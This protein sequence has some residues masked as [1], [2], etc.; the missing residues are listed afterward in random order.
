M[1]EKGSL[2]KLVDMEYVWLG[3]HNKRWMN[4]LVGTVVKYTKVTNVNDGHVSE[5][6]SVDLLVPF[7]SVKGNPVKW[8]C[9][10]YVEN[11][12][13]IKREPILIGRTP[14]RNNIHEH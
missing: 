13:E 8:V 7:L 5:I 11:L 14:E 12:E 1:I 2:V 9:G 6:C 4:G 10:I 3:N